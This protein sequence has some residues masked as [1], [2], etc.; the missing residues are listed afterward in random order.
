MTDRK[1]NYSSESDSDEVSEVV[2]NLM[3]NMIR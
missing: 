2:K 3:G 1:F